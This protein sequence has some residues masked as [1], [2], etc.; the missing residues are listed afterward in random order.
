MWAARVFLAVLAL[1]S[2]AHAVEY[3][4]ERGEFVG[5]RPDRPLQ[6]LTADVPC[7]D[8]DDQRKQATWTIRNMR[9]GEI[10]KRSDTR[11]RC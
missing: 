4:P 6:R 11:E 1:L 10:V 8:R 3:K 2:P 9:T 5:M 7:L